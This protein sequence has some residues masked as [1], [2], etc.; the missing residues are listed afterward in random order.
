MDARNAA[1]SW[2]S[3][4]HRAL[5]EWSAGGVQA[6]I[7]VS[8]LVPGAAVKWDVV[9]RLTPGISFRTAPVGFYEVFKK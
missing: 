5:H 7:S 1:G 3:S 8:V 4:C 6:F 2:C 9:V